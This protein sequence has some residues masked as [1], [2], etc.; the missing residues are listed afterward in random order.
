[1]MFATAGHLITTLTG[2]DLGTFFRRH[3]WLPMGMHSTFLGPYDPHLPGSGLPQADGYWWVP[4]ERSDEDDDDN[5]NSTEAGSYVRMPTPD[6]RGDEGAGAVMSNVLDYA[7]YL[8]VMMA[9]AGP[10]SRAGHHEL[11]RPRTF[12]DMHADLVGRLWED[13]PFGADRLRD[14]LPPPCALPFASPSNPSPRQNVA[15]E[16]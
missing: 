2:L 10:V 9:E 13:R 11:K 5:N 14:G 12:H 6:V 3:L 4:N 8:R 16:S 1:M 15:A 7:R